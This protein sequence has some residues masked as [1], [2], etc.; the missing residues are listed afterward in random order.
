MQ[1]IGRKAPTTVAGKAVGPVGYGMLGESVP[2]LRYP[3]Q[4]CPVPYD[5]RGPLPG[6]DGVRACMWQRIG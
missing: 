6:V 5:P 2:S 3:N 4:S 1:S